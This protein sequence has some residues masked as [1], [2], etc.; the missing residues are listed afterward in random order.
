MSMTIHERALTA[1]FCA[2]SLELIRARTRVM[3]GGLHASNDAEL[4]A[5]ARRVSRLLVTVL[6]RTDTP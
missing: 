5:T 4:A 3:E 6:E 1:N 2:I